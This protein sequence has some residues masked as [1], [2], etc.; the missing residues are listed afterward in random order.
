MFKIIA[1]VS[2]LAFATSTSSSAHT[3]GFKYQP[4]QEKVG[5]A[6]YSKVL[7]EKQLKCLADNIYFEAGNQKDIGMKAVAFATLNR[8]KHSAFP[9]TICEVVHQKIANVCQFS[10]TC[11]KKRKIQDYYAYY[12]SKR[13]AKLVMMNYGYM[14]DITKGATFFHRN[15][16][17]PGWA[18]PKKRTIIIGRHL[19]YTL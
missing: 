16:V 14:Y 8:L 18:N 11:F 3:T 7:D 12:R 1:L 15:D 2:L 4:I 5:V 9:D 17:W 6:P 19:F 13:M 10:W